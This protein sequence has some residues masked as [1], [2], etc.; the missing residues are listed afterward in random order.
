MLEVL[1]QKGAN[2]TPQAMICVD[3]V[4]EKSYGIITASSSFIIALRSLSH[5]TAGHTTDECVKVPVL[6]YTLSL[7]LV[8][9]RYSIYI[10]IPTSKVPGIRT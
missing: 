6:L 8:L 3:D 1:S 9:L 10:T 4:G 5:S 7:T 2:N